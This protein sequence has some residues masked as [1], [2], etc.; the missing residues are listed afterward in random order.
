MSSG[1]QSRF[2]RRTVAVTLILLALTLHVGLC[3]W[4]FHG[5]KE[6]SDI[7][8]GVDHDAASE[9]STGLCARGRAD[10]GFALVFGVVVPLA[11][12]S[13][14]AVL[15]LEW[16]LRD[17]LRGNRCC[18]CCGYLLTGSVSAQCPECGNAPKEQLK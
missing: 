6:G 15:T 4:V 13:S 2:A 10:R 11:L 14:C 5:N 16:R 8:V 18:C 1:I 3:K 12:L 9:G 17:R 7:I